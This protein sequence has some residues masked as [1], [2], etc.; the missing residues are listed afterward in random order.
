M[1]FEYKEIQDL[2]SVSLNDIDEHSS[3]T[4]ERQG[5]RYCNLLSRSKIGVYLSAELL[6]V[7]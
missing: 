6:R 4:R 5:I 1:S 2:P 3:G 7:I